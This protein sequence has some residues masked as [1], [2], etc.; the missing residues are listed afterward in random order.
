[1]KYFYVIVNPDKE[2]SVEVAEQIRNYLKGKG[3]TCYLNGECEEHSGKFKYTNADKVPENVQCIITLGGDGTLIQAARDLVG[4]GLPIVGV[5]MGHLGYLTQISREEEI[6]ERLKELVEDRF[7]LEQRMMLTGIIFHNGEKAVENVAL[8]DIVIARCGMLRLLN[9]R[10]YVN[11][12]FLNEYKADGMVIATPTGSTAYNLSAGGPIVA[13]NA[14]MTILTPICSHKLNSRSIVISAQDSV[15]IEILGDDEGGQ[16]AVFDGDTT[17][18][19]G[20]GDI[21]EINKSEAYTKMIK[22]KN[23]SFL[24]NL[25]DKMAGI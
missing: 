18:K 24:D 11:N 1:M 17:L 25:R 5:N 23:A 6:L 14:E 22:L 13:P 8:N 3:C 15:K 21:I 12:E 7:M 4:L 16:V 9:F 20:I 2:Q 19:L 10:I